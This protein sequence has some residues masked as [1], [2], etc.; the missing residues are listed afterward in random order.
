MDLNTFRYKLQLPYRQ[1]TWKEWLGEIFGRQISF[2]SQPEKTLIEKGQAKQIERFAS[3]A[4]RKSV[5]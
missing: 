1:E 5:V 2:E 4:D 3:I